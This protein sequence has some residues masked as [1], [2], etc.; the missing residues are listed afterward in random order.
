MGTLTSYFKSLLILVITLLAA[1]SY[2]AVYFAGYYVASKE[3]H[4]YY[5]AESLNDRVAAS[6]YTLYGDIEP[7]ASEENGSD[8]P[9]DNEVGDVP[10]QDSSENV[11][12]STAE[13]PPQEARVVAHDQALYDAYLI[14]FGVR[15]TADRYAEKLKNQGLAVRV[16][17]RENITAKGRKVTWYQVVLGPSAYHELLEVVEQLKYRDKLEGIVFKST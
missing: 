5:M 11:Q 14:G 13:N 10:L 8:A 16:V 4:S 12:G 17:S 15:R 1:I 7:T 6:L 2:C 3:L 9:S